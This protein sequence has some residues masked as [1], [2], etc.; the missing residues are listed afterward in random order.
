MTRR[1]GCYIWPGA[2]ALDPSDAA[3]QVGLG[4]LI[5][6]IQ[7]GH[8]SVMP[9][10]ALGQNRGCFPGDQ[11]QKYHGHTLCSPRIWI[12]TVPTKDL[13]DLSSLAS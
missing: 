13:D 10:A 7:A 1:T 11:G 2:R 3:M 8:D 4:G 5:L 6:H 12:L 9:Y